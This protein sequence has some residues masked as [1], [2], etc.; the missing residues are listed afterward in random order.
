MN[1]PHTLMPLSVGPEEAGQM[2]G[3]T[4]SAIYAAIARGDLPSFKSGKRRLILV[5]ELQTWINRLA[6]EN[7]R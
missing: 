2:T 4:R 6:T 3:H 5:S 1:Q 7:G